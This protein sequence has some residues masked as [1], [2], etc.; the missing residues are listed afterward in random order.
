M[1]NTTMSLPAPQVPGFN[2]NANRGPELNIVA[3]CFMCISFIAI[4][5]RGLSRLYTEVA[6]GLDDW[7]IVLAAVV[8]LSSPTAA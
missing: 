4:I 2:P 5:C 1:S 7:L 8:F 3:I 6:F